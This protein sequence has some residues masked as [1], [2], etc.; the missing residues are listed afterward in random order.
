MTGWGVTV[1]ATRSSTPADTSKTRV[2]A[3]NSGS[4]TVAPGAR[5]TDSTG[6]PAATASARSFSPSR[7]KARSAWRALWDRSSRRRR[8]TRWCRKFSPRPDA[9][10]VAVARLVALAR[11]DHQGAECGRVGHGQVGEH[12]AVDGDL[13]P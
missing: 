3:A 7:T 10:P 5:Y 9:S 4:A 8:W 6:T 1:S 11:H 13:G 2:A 12:L